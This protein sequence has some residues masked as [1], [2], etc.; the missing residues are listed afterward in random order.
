MHRIGALTFAAVLL[1]A[2]GARA[3]NDDL[4]GRIVSVD[5]FAHTV[6]FSDGRIAHYDPLWRV[7]VNGR[8]VA[9]T[10]VEPGAVIALAPATTTTTAVVPGPPQPAM[11]QV[12]PGTTVT[13]TTTTTTPVVAGSPGW[14]WSDRTLKGRVTR[15]DMAGT[16][17]VLADGRTIYVSAPT[18]VPT[19]TPQTVTVTQ[20]RPGDQVAIQV[21]QV[22]PVA[23]AEPSNAGGLAH[24][25]VAVPSYRYPGSAQVAADRVSIVRYPEA[26]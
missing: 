24:D 7:V 23:G 10:D 9:L 2:G 19:V 14:T 4:G 15:S 16:Q 21:Q 22:V 20:L 8:E 26:Q 13:T 11:A 3:Q 1:M 18:A 6:T 25:V 5:A 17:V 12:A